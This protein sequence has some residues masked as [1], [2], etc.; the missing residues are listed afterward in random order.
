MFFLTGTSVGIAVFR[1][2]LSGAVPPGSGS[3]PWIHVL[4]LDGP[5]GDRHTISDMH[6]PDH[7][8][9]RVAVNGRRTL[10]ILSLAALGA[11]AVTPA[12]A[13]NRQQY[14]MLQD[15]FP[16]LSAC[17]NAKF[18]E[19]NT[20]MKGIAIRV[21][22]DAT[23]LF[24][25]DL[26]RMAAGWTG[27]Y[28]TTHGVAF[29]GSH[30][31]HPAIEGDQKF[32]TAVVPGVAGADGVFAD[33]RSEPFGPVDHSLVHWDGLYVN[34]MDVQLNYTVGGTV[35][36]A[37]QPGSVAVGQQV[38]FTRT[39]RIDAPEKG[40]LFFKSHRVPQTFS[41]LVA[42]VQGATPKV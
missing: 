37:E 28:V 17:I 15:D 7:L 36:V 26:C 9:P 8:L 5:G 10:R 24:D 6:P 38:A 22:N 40:F 32:G 25:T 35:H 41:L 33:H 19:G 3:N 12:Q 11:W 27:G 14:K 31:H 2:G 1:T 42:D 4:S 39:F 34:G 29:D 21:G 30:G 18:P 13:Q 23:M 20:A 16:F